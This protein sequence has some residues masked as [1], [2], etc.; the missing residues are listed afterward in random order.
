MKEDGSILPEEPVFKIKSWKMIYG[1]VEAF[2]DREIHG[3]VGPDYATGK[4]KCD[5]CEG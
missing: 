5:L 2:K 3:D 4:I 1:A